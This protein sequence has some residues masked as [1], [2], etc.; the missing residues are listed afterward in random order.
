[1][2]VAFVGWSMHLGCGRDNYRAGGSF[3]KQAKIVSDN[4]WTSL[5]CKEAIKEIRWQSLSFRQR[6]IREGK[7][8]GWANVVR[9]RYVTADN[10][11]RDFEERNRDPKRRALERGES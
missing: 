10:R 4:W 11:E 9:P 5:L 6:C 2:G 1:M 7:D 3:F 8:M